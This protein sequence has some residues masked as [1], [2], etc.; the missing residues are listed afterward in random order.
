MF[1]NRRFEKSL[2]GVSLFAAIMLA[3]AALYLSP[4]HEI[5]ATTA[6]VIAQFLTLTATLLGFDYKF[7][8][9]HNGTEPPSG[10]A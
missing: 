7:N 4:V 6:M 5:A 10:L 3:F 2:A 1:T 9:A 8:P